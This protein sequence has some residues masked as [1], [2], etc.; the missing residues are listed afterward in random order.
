MRTTASGTGYVSTTHKLC[1]H[2]TALFSQKAYICVANFSILTSMII[3]KHLFLIY[4]SVACIIKGQAQDI[5]FGHLTTNEGLSNNAVMTMYQDERG[6]IW[7]GT[8]NGANLYNGNEFKIYK[9]KKND[10][11]SLIYNNVNQITGNKNGEVYFMTSKGISAFNI[12]NNTFTTLIRKEVRA[13]FFHKQLYAAH[14]NKLYKYDG[15]QFGTYYELPQGNKITALHVSDNYI[16]IGTENHGLFRLNRQRQLSHPISKGNISTI[17]QDS[18][19]K[20]WIGSWEHGLFVMDDNQTVNFRYEEKDPSS[21]SSDF[22]R[23]CCEDKQGNLWIGTFNGLNMFRPDS[24]TFTRHLKRENG[25]SHS[26]IWSLLCDHQGSI[27]AGTYFGGVNYFNPKSQIYNHYQASKTTD[28]GLSSSIVGRITEDSRHNLWIGTEGGGLNKYDPQKRKFEWYKH[29][30]LPGSLS[31]DNVKALYYDP[32]REII[33][34]GTH[35]GGLN[36]M[37]LKTKTFTHYLHNENDPESLPSNIIRDIIPYKKQ[38]L[39]ASHAGV[40]IFNPET[41]K[42]KRL[43]QTPPYKITDAKG[44]FIDHRGTLWI[45]GDGNGVYSYRFDSGEITNYK[46]NHASE[47]GLSSNSINRIYEDS[48]HRLWLCSNESG[49]D[50]YRYDTDDFLNFDEARNELASD[51]V[52]DVCELSPGRLLFTTDVGFSIL[53]CS[54]QKFKNYDRKNGVPLLAVNERSLY[55]SKQGEIFIGGIDGMVSFKEKDIN[56]TSEDYAISPFRLIVNGGEVTVNDNSGILKE[57]LSVTDRIVLKSSQSMFS[58]EYAVSNYISTAKDEI[59]Y[60]LEGFSKTWTATRGQ[61]TITYTNLNPGKYTLLVRM[62]NNRP[63]IPESRLEIVILPPFYR[64]VWAYLFYFILTGGVLYFLIRTYNNRIKLQESLKYEQKRTED[65]ER[66][67]Q[68]KLRFF[69]NISHEFRTPLT[70]IIGQME[71][72]LQ[73]PSFAPTVYNKILSVYKS[74]LQLRELITELLDFRKQEQGYMTIKV[75]EHNIVDFLYENY[76]LF[77]EYA[78]QRQITFNFHK[79][80]DCINIWYDAKQLQKV[81]NNLISNAFKHT[82]EGGEISVSVRKGNREAIIEVTDSGTGISP[83]DIDKIF[84]RF[85]QADQIESLSYT[86]TGIGLSLTKGIIELH[87]GTIDVYSEPGEG[88]T[89]CVH[90]KTGNAHFTP[91]QLDKRQEEAQLDLENVTHFQEMRQQSLLDQEIMNDRTVEKSKEARILIVEDNGSLR[92]MLVRIFETF[93]IV[94]TA[95]DGREGW[96]KVQSEHPNIVLSDIVMP[97]MSGTE[98]CK[99]IKENIETCHIPVV[100]L[101]A[102]TAIEHN[103]EGLRLGA[104]DYITKPFN[105]NILLSRCNNLVNNRILLQEKFSKQPQA[106][107]QILA[108]NPLDKELVDKAMRVIEKHIDNVEFNVDILAHETGIARTKLFTKLKAI[109]GQTPYEFILTVRLKRAAIMLKENPEFNIS[110][111][112]DRLGFS[113]PRQFSKCFKE[114]YHVVPQIYRKGESMNDEV[115]KIE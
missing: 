28:E 54:T 63:Q 84:D 31:H 5:S 89:F 93:Y 15:K 100:L 14:N 91:E 74:S 96:E 109:T 17:F 35:L 36:K 110:E 81:M 20:Y 37:D 1:T 53:D 106:T 16:L 79:T 52:Y 8:R 113:S 11:N 23:C 29:N 4:L 46:Y 24:R 64:S 13:M 6:F 19:G 60:F 66:L 18:S 65:I 98:L 21:I 76:L 80:N 94:S 97:E 73:V 111:I 51:C 42:V 9:F 7:L 112:S 2:I 3:K 30:N 99:L 27:W 50:L 40:C 107:H 92:E 56:Y 55:K 102:R 108:T 87:H 44:L 58:I 70:L 38:L 41:G 101:T 78:I 12:R 114:K 115:E 32:L 85:Y 26:S 104:D 68:A 86:G 59:E 90:L 45:C 82:K 61:N 34:I 47:H 43:F 75:N 77:Q 72:L 67:N 71:M 57:D 22:I 103:L 39:I 95:S 105:V 25:L 62:K 88:T 48:Q 69:T 49:I 10:P 33:W 83:E